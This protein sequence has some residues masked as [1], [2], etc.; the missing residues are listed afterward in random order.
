MAHA[1]CSAI[2]AQAVAVIGSVGEQDVPGSCH[3]NTK[4]F[5][6]SR[7]PSMAAELL[8]NEPLRATRR[9]APQT[10]RFLACALD[11]LCVAA[12]IELRAIGRQLQHAVGERRQEMTVMADE[13]HGA[14]EPR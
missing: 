8:L 5:R 13:E 14:F 10:R 4:G 7:R 6:S 12:A 3:I 11:V 2:A 1:P 9:S